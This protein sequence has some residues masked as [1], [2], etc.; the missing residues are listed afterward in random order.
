MRLHG[1]HCR[2][3]FVSIAD[4]VWRPGRKAGPQSS[5]AGWL[6]QRKSSVRQVVAMASSSAAAGASAA[7]EEAA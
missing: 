6:Q 4:G 1:G 3:G 7:V 5:E 2:S